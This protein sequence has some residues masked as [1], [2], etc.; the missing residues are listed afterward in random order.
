MKEFEELIR[1]YRVERSDNELTVW[2]NVRDE[3][4][5]EFWIRHGYLVYYTK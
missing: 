1:E 3:L 2:F 5:V 4:K